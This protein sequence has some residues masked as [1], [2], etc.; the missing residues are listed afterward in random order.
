[1]FTSFSYTLA[2]GQ[3]IETLSTVDHAATTS[4]N[5]NGNNFVNTIQGNAG[6]NV[7]DGRFGND[8]L[9]GLGGHDSFDF[10]T[11]LDPVN[12]VP[13][14][15]DFTVGNDKIGLSHVVFATLA[16]QLQA[17]QFHI[18]S[19][20]DSPDERIIYNAGTGA[21]IYDSNGNGEGSAMQFA[22]LPK[23]LALSNTDFFIV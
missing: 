21:L 14:V 18:G 2:N 20:A 8:T 4:I 10:T 16:G 23:N 17:A 19:A 9:T 1:V 12:N 22:T 6:D 7:I 5:L 13:A 3:E 15:T 11:G